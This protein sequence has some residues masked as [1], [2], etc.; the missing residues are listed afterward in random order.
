MRLFPA[1]SDNGKYYD[2]NKRTVPEIGVSHVMRVFEAAYFGQTSEPVAPP[3]KPAA[4]SGLL[5]QSYAGRIICDEEKY[6]TN[7]GF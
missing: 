2:S 6:G 3:T 4:G 5:D 7:I 1:I